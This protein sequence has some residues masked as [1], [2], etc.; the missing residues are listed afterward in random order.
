MIYGVDAINTIPFNE[1]P[2]ITRRKYL[3][4]VKWP[5]YFPFG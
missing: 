1:L 4:E 2:G 5:L 3:K